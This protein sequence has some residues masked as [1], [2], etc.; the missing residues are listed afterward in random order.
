MRRLKTERNGLVL[1]RTGLPL[2]IAAVGIV[3]VATGDFD[4]KTDA[5]TAAGVV[6]IG[7]GLMVWMLNWMFRMSID[8]NLDREREEMAREYYD[9]HGHW[10]DEQP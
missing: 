3:L 6:L 8:S 1:V 4:S 10:P 7:I 2:V 9:K 5:T